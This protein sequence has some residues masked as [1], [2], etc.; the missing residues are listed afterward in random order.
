V[1][2]QTNAVI[3]GF[4]TLMFAK[5]VRLLMFSDNR[6]VICRKNVTLKEIKGTFILPQT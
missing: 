2:T 6:G 5:N 1:G 3:V 4:A